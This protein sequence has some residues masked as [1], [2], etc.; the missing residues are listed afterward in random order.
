MP[1]AVVFMGTPDFAVPTLE[2]LLAAGHRVTAVY[3]QPARPAGR[4][5]SVVATPVEQAARRHGL[6]I[7]TPVDFRDGADVA[8]LAATAPDVIVVAA[9]GLLL[10][11]AVL[12]IPRHGCFNLHASLLPR[13]RGAAPIHRAVMAGDE[14]VGVM[15]MRMERGLDTGPVAMSARSLLSPDDTTGDLHDRLKIVGAGLMVDALRRMEAGTLSVAP[16]ADAGIL[17]A[18]KIDKGETR[19]D[20]A[21]PA[22][23]VRR[24]IH[25][26][27]PFPGA[28]CEIMTPQGA[29][30]LKILR[31]EYVDASGPPATI[32]D[33]RL[34]IACGEGAVR[35]LLVQRA[36]R[37]V[38]DRDTALRGLDLAPGMI[39]C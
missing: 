16:Q 6:D 18:H 27:S 9:Y 7:R 13:W 35:P 23:V 1:L 14:E 11:P 8:T 21:K 17:Y 38:M 30:R 5:M 19:I 32:L 29:E 26:L 39:V 15:V 4:G 24:H 34:A 28:W 12:A 37:K 25:G 33:D 20:W 22:S 31:C 2:A 3:T 36:G 10:P